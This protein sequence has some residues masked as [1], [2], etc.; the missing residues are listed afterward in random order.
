MVS[1]MLFVLRLLGVAVGGRGAEAPA[2]NAL[3]HC[4]RFT[5]DVGRAGRLSK[6]GL[7]VV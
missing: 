2:S 5:F 6:K 3:F 7:L 4:P 1:Q